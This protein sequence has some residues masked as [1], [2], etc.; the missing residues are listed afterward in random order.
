MTSDTQDSIADPTAAS[1]EART[2]PPKSKGGRLSYINERVR[3]VGFVAVDDLVDE[4]EVSRMTIH[5]DLD[6][7]QSSGALRKVRGGASAHRSTQFESDLQFRL[8][9]ETDEKQRIAAA[10]AQFANDGDVVLI[11][12]STTALGLV[13]H[14]EERAP[15]TVITNFLPVLERLSANPQMNVIG[16]GGQYVARYAAFLGKLCEENLRSLFADV[17]FISSSSL[18]N[19]VLYHQD[20]QVL[21]TKRAM[22]EAS[23]RRVL[24]M[25][26]SKIGQAALFK[27]G[28]VS[29]FTHVVVDDKTDPAIVSMIEDFGVDVVVA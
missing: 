10:A 13:P 16:L 1:V 26:H 23:D 9:A 17:A 24:L 2:A 7:L 6:E 12:D 28:D 21:A 18:R 3:A 29:E 4:L 14:L 11:D 15:F 20:Q 22:M 27:L 5:R 8:T 25:D 19:G